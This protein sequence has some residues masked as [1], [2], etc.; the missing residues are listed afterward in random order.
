MKLFMVRVLGV[1]DSRRPITV[2]GGQGSLAKVVA[3]LVSEA[4]MGI[5]IHCPRVIVHEL[6]RNYKMWAIQQLG[7]PDKIQD[8]QFSLNFR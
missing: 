4:I 3:S 6:H 2:L 1:Q 7:S 8:I 5:V